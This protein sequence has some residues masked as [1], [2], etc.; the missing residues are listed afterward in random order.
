MHFKGEMEGNRCL[1]ESLKY[2]LRLRDFTMLC[3]GL[4]DVTTSQIHRFG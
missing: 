2:G 3:D 1:E 4:M